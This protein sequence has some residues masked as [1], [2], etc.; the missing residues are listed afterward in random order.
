M[1]SF[2]RR[3]LY[4]VGRI[5][6]SADGLRRKGSTV[7]FTKRFFLRECW[8]VGSVLDSGKYLLTER[9]YSYNFEFEIG[10]TFNG[11]RIRRLQPN[12]RVDP[13]FSVKIP[14]TTKALIKS[15]SQVG[16]EIWVGG[17]FKE[18]GGTKRNGIAR[19]SNVDLQTFDEWMEVVALNK[20]VETGPG[21]DPDGDGFSNLEEYATGTNPLDAGSTPSIRWRERKWKVDVNPDA[22]D[23][24]RE[25][26]LSNDLATWRSPSPGEVIVEEKDHQFSWK[27][28]SGARFSRLVF[29]LKKD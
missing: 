29:R 6:R 8:L 19:L 23:V 27:V 1:L 12:G 25:I 10:G 7:I 17:N 16:G 2:F 22:R 14:G 15:A 4:E 18:I 28:L 21:H 20:Q 13:T 5:H 11:S 9:Q 26:E 24:R 3:A